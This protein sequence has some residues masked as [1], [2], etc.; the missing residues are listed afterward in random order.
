MPKCDLRN[1]KSAQ[2]N[3]AL[4]RRRWIGAE[5]D[6]ETW[7]VFEEPTPWWPILLCHGSRS[8]GK[9]QVHS[10]LQPPASSSSS[11]KG[12][13]LKCTG[14]GRRRWNDPAQ[15]SQRQRERAL[16]T[17]MPSAT[18]ECCA[19]TLSAPTRPSSKTLAWASEESSERI[20]KPLKHALANWEGPILDR[21]ALLDLN[22][23]MNQQR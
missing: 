2:K 21:Q 14:R 17:G 3:I 13:V 19:I 4:E 10:V 9:C 12:P 11:G 5:I 20:T 23:G 7:D 22:S 16:D 1:C 6:D 15:V 18:L 8:A